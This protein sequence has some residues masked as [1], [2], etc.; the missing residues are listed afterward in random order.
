MADLTNPPEPLQTCHWDKLP[1]EMV[2]HICHFAYAHKSTTKFI[3]R[4]EWEGRQIV[5]EAENNA[6]AAM[7]QFVHKV[8]D[9]M[10]SSSRSA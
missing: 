7:K 4:A 8:N 3:R 2:D 1:K 9:F 5:F 10:V 6:A